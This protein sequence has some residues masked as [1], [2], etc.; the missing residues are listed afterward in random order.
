MVWSPSTPKN[1]TKQRERDSKS[2]DLSG[3]IW[4]RRKVVGSCLIVSSHWLILCV[5]FF[6]IK[7]EMGPANSSDSDLPVNSITQ[8]L[9][10]CLS[11]RPEPWPCLN[12][13]SGFLKVPLKS[14]PPC[15][16]QLC[17]FGGVTLQP[18]CYTG[19]KKV[20]VLFSN[21]T[22]NSSDSIKML[23]NNT[24]KHFHLKCSQV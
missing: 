21:I 5:C 17:S 22:K 13:K 16:H 3:Y 4:I 6:N 2:H 19:S 24:L 11:T 15:T 1:K 8:G 14:F 9:P 20:F 10:G 23:K 7:I 18:T 12:S